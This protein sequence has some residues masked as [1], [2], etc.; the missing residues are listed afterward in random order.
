M[1]KSISNLHLPH[2]KSTAGK[3]S[4]LL[5]PPE[6]VLIP[7]SMHAGAPAIPVVKEGDNVKIG[8]LI[9]Q[10]D[11]KVSSPVHATISGVV[12]GIEDYKTTAGKTCQA[13]RIKSD[14]KMD[15]H[16]SVVPRK[17]ENLDEFLGALKE[18]GIVGLGG[19]AFPVWSKFDVCRT[20]HIET[21]LVNGAECEPFITSDDRMMVEHSDLVKDGIEYLDKFISADE[22]VIG[23]E[24]N[25]PEAIS[26]LTE[27]F[28]D[29]PKVKVKS[30]KSTYPQGAKQVL[31]YNAT[32][33]VV[34]EGMRLAAVGAIIINVSS[35]AKLAE[36]MNTG[37]PLVSK[38]ITIDGS[39]VKNPQNVT[40]PIGT[41]I[42]YIMDKI[43]GFKA[44][45][46]KILYGGPMMGK[47]ANSLDDVVIKATN[48]LV[49]LDEKDSKATEPSPCLHCGKCVSVCPIGLNPTDF[50]SAMDIEDENERFDVLEK[51]Q[52]G[53]CIECGCCSFIC[54]AHRPL[55]DTNGKA[56]RFVKKVKADRKAAAEAAK[57]N[58]TAAEGGKK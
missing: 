15:V 46:G 19:A 48:A 28:K 51:A 18:S 3:Q 11:G 37:M 31:L 57:A 32:G 17:C 5:D 2:Y 1:K 20:T 56:K 53:Q 24:E 13:I 39:A 44:E 40:I 38:T 33:K 49:M 36:F 27:T 45:P 23:I 42:S 54:P 21:V 58:E 14:G 30:L 4:V 26:I 10:E 6:E 7:L 16:E 43:G 9:A 22:Y 29:N 47:C 8:Q 34:T 55:A 52:V 25:K 50:I 12:T 35:L 41:S